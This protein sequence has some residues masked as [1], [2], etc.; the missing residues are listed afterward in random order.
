MVNK[1][2]GIRPW[3]LSVIEYGEMGKR[4]GHWDCWASM[5]IQGVVADHEGSKDVL[6]IRR[7]GLTYRRIEALT[8]K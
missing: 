2:S 3:F 1:G 8:A 4:K 6:E 5:H 7:K